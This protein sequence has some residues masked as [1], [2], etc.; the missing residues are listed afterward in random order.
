MRAK[1]RPLSAPSPPL[2]ERAGEGVA[3]KR[4]RGRKLRFLHRP[5][6]NA[7]LEFIGRATGSPAGEAVTSIK[8]N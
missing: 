8:A 1:N 2:R 7:A 5:A 3:R 4:G 6:I